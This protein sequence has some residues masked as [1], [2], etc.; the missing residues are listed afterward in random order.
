[1]AFLFSGCG[2]S[3]KLTTGIGGGE[4][5]TCASAANKTTDCKDAPQNSDVVSSLIQNPWCATIDKNHQYRVTFSFSND[6]S[7]ISK[8]TF[9]VNDDGS[10]G[11][12]LGLE[13][14]TWKY[15]DG[16]LSL[17]LGNSPAIMYR[18]TL[19]SPNDP[20]TRSFTLQSGEGPLWT[21]KKC[22]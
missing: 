17:R 13:N 10:R 5:K 4:G 19:Y 2:E 9:W 15:D 20:S 14:G 1:M 11:T 8:D 18:F 22:N 16:V 7:M 6:S 12:G 3:P 21:Y